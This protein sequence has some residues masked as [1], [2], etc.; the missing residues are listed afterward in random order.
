MKQNATMIAG[1]LLPLL[2]MS[3]VN[4][5]AGPNPDVVINRMNVN[6]ELFENS[7]VRVTIIAEII[8]SNEHNGTVE[9]IAFPVLP[10]GL[11]MENPRK[12]VQSFKAI[13][14]NI[15]VDK[16]KTKS[17]NDVILV[18]FLDGLRPGDVRN[19]SFSFVL[20]PSTALVKLGDDRY[21]FAYRLYMPNAT[22]DYNKST[23]KALLPY[24]AGVTKISSDGIVE[25]DA[26]SERLTAVW[27]CFGPPRGSGWDFILEFKVLGGTSPVSPSP[28]AETTSIPNVTP[29]GGG[30]FPLLELVTFVVV[31]NAI[32]GALAF[33]LYRRAVKRKVPVIEGWQASQEEEF[34]LTEEVVAQYREV[35][36]KLDKDER[37]IV[38]ILLD[39]NGKV[40]QKDL[41][42]LTG[43]SKSK[44]SRI[45]KRLDSLGVV[46]RTS[47][48]KTKIVELSPVLMEIFREQG[49]I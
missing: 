40:E 12:G 16:V 43:F 49:E 11:A 21:R 23:M 36:E 48:G 4:I 47:V 42:E 25:M 45:L 14:G 41:P 39:K 30:T 22:V 37:S 6:A 35:L 20:K 1:I 19:V 26:L 34:L 28:P 5:A 24:G 3:V 18:K 29:Q 27:R 46:R 2:I 38:D 15:T 9:S 13:A 44:V 33:L 31:S 17:Y 10:I 8:V 7:S 32:T